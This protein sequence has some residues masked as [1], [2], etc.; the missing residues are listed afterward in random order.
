MILLAALVNLIVTAY[1]A[2]L[3]VYVV[4]CWIKDPRAQAIREWLKKWYEPLLQPLRRFFK[5]V[6]TGSYA[7]DYTP[8]VLLFAIVLARKL[9]I[10]VLI[11][12]Y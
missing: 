5:P 7:V 11:L 1:L 2:G 4:S 8:M 12:P 10:A 3:L 6:R 9:L